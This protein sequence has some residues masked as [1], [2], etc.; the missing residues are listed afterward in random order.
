MLANE[1]RSSSVVRARSGLTK[2]PLYFSTLPESRAENQID[3]AVRTWILIY[4]LFR[5]AMCADRGSIITRTSSGVVASRQIS[6]V[7][8]SIAQW[9][10]PNIYGVMSPR[11]REYWSGLKRISKAQLRCYLQ[12]CGECGYGPTV[13]RC[14]DGGTVTLHGQVPGARGDGDVIISESLSFQHRLTTSSTPP[15]SHCPTFADQT[16]TRARTMQFADKCARK[17]HV[18]WH[19]Y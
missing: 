10:R 4:L 7:L 16:S 2:S 15:P 14:S 13:Q 11:T 19:V 12:C 18:R 5:A 3:V 17:V 1:M 8:I 9:V 6:V